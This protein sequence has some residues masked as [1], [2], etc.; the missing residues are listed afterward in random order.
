MRCLLIVELSFYGQLHQGD[1]YGD[2][3]C[4]VSLFIM[5]KM[6]LSGPSD[7]EEQFRLETAYVI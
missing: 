4:G 2:W 7:R 6:S 5:T 3:K 1:L